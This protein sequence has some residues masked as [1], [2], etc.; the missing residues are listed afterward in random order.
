LP[1][2]KHPARTIEEAA[3]ATVSAMKT[4]AEATEGSGSGPESARAAADGVR[5]SAAGAMASATN[6]ASNLGARVPDLA[7]RGR[8][9]FEDAN[10]RIQAGTDETLTV[11]TAVSFG[12][13][14]GLLIGGASRILVAAALIPVAMMGLTLLDRAAKGRLIVR[15]GKREP[16][17]S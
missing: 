2:L 10:Q 6:R 17:G 13:A 15:A 5:S 1:F 9:A 16:T 3:M 12:L 11:G 8:L 14:V 4:T 7:D